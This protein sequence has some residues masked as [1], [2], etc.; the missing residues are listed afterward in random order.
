MTE[1]CSKQNL[2]VNPLPGL[3]LGASRLGKRAHVLRERAIGYSR[4]NHLVIDDALHD[5]LLSPLLGVPKE[6]RLCRYRFAGLS[7]A[8]GRHC[9]TR[10]SQEG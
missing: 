8:C 6:S 2:P 4:Q 9:A 5:E 7:E 3:P 1:T 10:H